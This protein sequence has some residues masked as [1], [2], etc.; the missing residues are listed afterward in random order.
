MKSLNSESYGFIDCMATLKFGVTKYNSVRLR[1]NKFYRYGLKEFK[2]TYD[3]L[4]DKLER[5]PSYREFL[6]EIDT[7]FLIGGKK[8][9]KQTPEYIKIE[10]TAEYENACDDLYYGGGFT[11]WYKNQKR[12]GSN[13]SPIQARAV[14]KAAFDYMANC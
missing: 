7:E 14:W 2:E 12:F 6:Y 5:R 8:E 9:L 4:C 11:S 1:K 10:F 13:I 3:S